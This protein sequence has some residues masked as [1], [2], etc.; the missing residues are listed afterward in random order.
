[1]TKRD[2]PLTEKLLRPF[3]QVKVAEIQCKFR[4]SQGQPLG[5]RPTPPP[6][7]QKCREELVANFGGLLR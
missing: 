1:M 3:E 6:Q 4:V 5:F 2:K 7:V